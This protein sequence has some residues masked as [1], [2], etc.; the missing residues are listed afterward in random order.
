M[1]AYDQ[2]SWISSLCVILHISHV[3]LHLSDSMNY[4]VADDANSLRQGRVWWCPRI[5]NPS[6]WGIPSTCSSTLSIDASSEPQ[7][8]VGFVECHHAKIGINWW[9]SGRMFATTSTASR[10]LLPRL[11]GNTTSRFLLPR[12]SQSLDC[13]TTLSSSRHCL[14]HNSSMVP[15]VLGWPRIPPLFRT[16]TKCRGVSSAQHSASTTFQQE[17]CTASCGSS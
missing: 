6:S 4:L 5:L 2:I 8:T 3:I 12:L 11:L 16:I 14:Q 17:P 9:M 7:A 10:F 15:Q 1:K 13:F